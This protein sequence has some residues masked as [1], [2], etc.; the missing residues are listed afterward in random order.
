MN[1]NQKT[2]YAMRAV[3]ELARREGRGPVKAA[4]V[5]EAQAIPLRFLENILNQLKQGGIVESRRGKEGGYL[6]SRPS[7]ELT[8]GD[9]I[10]LIDGA[11][12]SVECDSPSGG[13]RCPLRGDCVFLPLWEKA[14]KA[15]EAVYES[16]TF[17]E[18]V[19]QDHHR[20]TGE[21]LTYCI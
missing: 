19:D 3:F 17:K 15:L 20:E 8:A 13:D 11:V 1:L 18:L 5:A 21:A 2:Q 7:H 9:V 4:D 10:G 14:R 12:F 16:T 6:L